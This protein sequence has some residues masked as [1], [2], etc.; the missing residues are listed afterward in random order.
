MSSVALKIAVFAIIS[1]QGGESRNA[2][3]VVIRTKTSVVKMLPWKLIDYPAFR[4]VEYRRRV[5]IDVS[6]GAIFTFSKSVPVDLTNFLNDMIQTLL[7]RRKAVSTAKYSGRQIA[8]FLFNII[9]PWDRNG[10]SGLRNG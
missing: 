9:S 5:I 10:L 7:Y 4:D 8:N 2:D 6:R 1:I 3:R